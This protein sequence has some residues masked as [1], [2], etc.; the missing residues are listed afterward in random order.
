MQ[1]EKLQLMVTWQS[2]S[3]MSNMGG[4]VKQTRVLRDELLAEF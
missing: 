4:V 2:D 1:R 3:R